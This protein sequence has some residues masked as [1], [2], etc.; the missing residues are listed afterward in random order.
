MTNMRGV[1][2][3]YIYSR[4]ECAIM[5]LGKLR[6]TDVDYS[7]KLQLAQFIFFVL[8]IWRLWQMNTSLAVILDIYHIL[9]YLR[10]LEHLKMYSSHLNF[11]KGF[12]MF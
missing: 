10:Y 6:S 9:V 12:D 4:S 2:I 7:R 8:I 11:K 1:Q 3:H 5:Y